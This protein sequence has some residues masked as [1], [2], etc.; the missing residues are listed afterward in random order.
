MQKKLTNIQPNASA[1]EQAAEMAASFLRDLQNISTKLNQFERELAGIT[2]SVVRLEQTA[3]ADSFVH[4]FWQL[5]GHRRYAEIQV[6]R[7]RALLNPALLAYPCPQSRIEALNVIH[8][9]I[10]R[11]ESALREMRLFWRELSAT[12]HFMLG[13]NGIL[14]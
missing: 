7:L 10:E 12:Y 4:Q 11:T 2:E 3:G 9:Q 5:S 14:V 13:V 8:R 1:E 6:R